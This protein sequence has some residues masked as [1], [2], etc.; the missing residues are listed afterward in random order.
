MVLSN[1][2]IYSGKGTPMVS[3]QGIATI[4]HYTCFKQG[5]TKEEMKKT[6][7]RPPIKEEEVEKI[8]D[9]RDIFRHVQSKIAEKIT[10]G[11]SN[12]V[13]EIRKSI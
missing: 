10:T 6:G 9:K 5:L 3:K 7:L 1:K 11:G 8:L 12:A 13:Q 2:A 4:S